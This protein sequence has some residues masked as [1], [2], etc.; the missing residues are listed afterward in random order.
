[1]PILV[2]FTMNTEYLHDYPTIRDI[3]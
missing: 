3:N 2:I 1:M